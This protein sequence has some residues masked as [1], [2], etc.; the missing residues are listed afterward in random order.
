MISKDDTR[1][2]LM[3]NWLAGLPA[4]L[5]LQPQTLRPASSDAS[6]RRYFRLDGQGRTLVVMD[7][8]P[9]KE[10][11]RPFVA[12]AQRLLAQGLHVPEVLAQDTEAG[13]LLLSD[14]GTT[15]YY[16]RLLAPIDEV[17]LQ[18]LYRPTIEALVQLQQAPHADL[19]RY[20]EARLLDELALFP[21]WYVSRHGGHVLTDD[22]RNSLQSLFAQLA[23]HN[24]AQP[25]VFVHRDFHS[26]NLLLPQEGAVGVIDFQ[27][28]VAGPI[29]YD[30]ASLLFD[31]RTTWDEAR[32]L[33]WG[34][35]YWERARALG[36]PVAGDI[37][38]F[39]RDWEWMGLQRNLRILGVFARLGLRDGKTGYLVQHMPRV[40]T[41]VRQV[42]DR[43]GVFRPLLRLMDVIDTRLAAKSSGG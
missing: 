42:A 41:Y 34:I 38:D 7:A 11:C 26:P 10:D 27:D 9:E 16:E 28:A 22:E 33:D 4:E 24:A 19:P 40:N 18:A 36:L 37:A 30:V 29:T 31:A 43:Y 1:Y 6:F 3:A 2:P 17:T 13:F 35:R 39:H 32:Q 25:V 20:D 5:G 15:T 8:P 21:E 23:A 14:L 12:I